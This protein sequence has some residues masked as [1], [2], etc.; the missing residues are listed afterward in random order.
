MSLLSDSEWTLLHSSDGADGCAT[1]IA[2]LIIGG[3][4]RAVGCA[5]SKLTESGSNDVH[6]SL[7]PGPPP[8]LRGQLLFLVFF[9]FSFRALLNW[10][11]GEAGGRMEAGGGQRR[12]ATID[13]G[14]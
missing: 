14:S 10:N 11:G 1:E 4:Q 13:S 9:F 3:F 5:F 2:V 6:S 7:S 8:P 12:L